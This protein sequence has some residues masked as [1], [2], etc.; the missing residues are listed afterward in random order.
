MR[1]SLLVLSS[2]LVGTALAGEPYP[3]D[4]LTVGPLRFSRIQFPMPYGGSRTAC[5]DVAV[6]TTAINPPNTT[7][8]TFVFAEYDANGV[9]VLPL[10]PVDEGYPDSYERTCVCA[11]GFR[12][13]V[14][15][16]DF[17]S[18]IRAR[19]FAPG[20]QPMGPS[21]VV[22]DETDGLGDTFSVSTGNGRVIIAFDRTSSLPIAPPT[23]VVMRV[24]TS[25]GEL[26]SSLLPIASWQSPQ[27]HEL[28][29]ARVQPDGSVLHLYTR[30]P[31]SHPSVSSTSMDFSQ[32]SEWPL[33]S[34]GL[35]ASRFLSSP[36]VGVRVLLQDPEVDDYF[37]LPVDASGQPSGSLQP[38]PYA[39]NSIAEQAN[40][41]FIVTHR[42]F[43]H[44]IASWFDSTGQLLA[45]NV[46]YTRPEALP[47]RVGTRL[48]VSENGVVW[49]GWT[50][51]SAIGEP[52]QRY[53]TILRP[54][55]PGDMTGDGR[56][57]NFDIDPFVLALVDRD[58]YAAL[59]PQFAGIIDALGD[60]DGDGVLTNF[61]IDPFVDALVNGP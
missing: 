13:F 45:A 20:G 30:N 26:L 39:V 22:K 17:G 47:R 60:M 4:L 15:T 3:A 43:N 7:L 11:D 58:A 6:F 25:S 36:T 19:V 34:P 5:G 53:M 40:G 59:Y 28:G 55:V 12:W 21:F 10:R 31:G 2:L 14:W 33:G 37:L 51:T 24:F 29:E 35:Y 61:D 16:D 50:D 44:P 54:I 32:F 1:L 27:W 41:A 23:D 56:L 57:D 8:A 52:G 38:F 9:E 18:V 48:T 49:A 46:P 42:N